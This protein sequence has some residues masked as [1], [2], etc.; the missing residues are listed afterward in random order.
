M[1]DAWKKKPKG[2]L[3]V[4]Y[5]GRKSK[6]LILNKSKISKLAEGFKFEAATYRTRYFWNMKPI[7][8]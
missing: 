3:M 2:G 4:N 5:D 6:K 7:S 8:C 1:F